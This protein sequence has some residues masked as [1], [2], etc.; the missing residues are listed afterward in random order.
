MIRRMI[1]ADYRHTIDHTTFDLNL[2]GNRLSSGSNFES[3]VWCLLST[4]G[5]T[6]YLLPK[7]P[8]LSEMKI[9]IKV[10]FDF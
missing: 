2:N 1:Y 7:N 5:N 9:A 10:H 6:I 8:N 4:Q 3:S